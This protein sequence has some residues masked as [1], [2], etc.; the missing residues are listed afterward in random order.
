[1]VINPEDEEAFKRSINYPKRGLGDT[2]VQKILELAA[3]F[4]ISPWNIISE[5]GKYT[6]AFQFGN[7]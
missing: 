6:R 5:S 4:N 1:M 7:S 3:N 2:T